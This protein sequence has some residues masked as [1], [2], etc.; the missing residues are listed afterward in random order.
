[1]SAVGGPTDPE[2]RSWG[3]LVVRGL[4]HQALKGNLMAFKEIFDRNDGKGARSDKGSNANYWDSKSPSQRRSLSRGAINAIRDI[5][6][7]PH[8]ED[9]ARGEISP[10]DPEAEKEN[11]D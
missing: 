3:E 5:Y 6:G 7:L 10:K 4:V 9:E 8:V 2:K 1:M 11:S